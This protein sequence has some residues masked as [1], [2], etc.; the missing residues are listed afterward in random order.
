MLDLT[1][2]LNDFDFCWLSIKP[3]LVF[4]FFVRLCIVLHVHVTFYG[5]FLREE[6]N[7][8][9]MRY[10]H[11]SVRLNLRYTCT[12]DREFFRIQRWYSY[13]FKFM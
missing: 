12:Q 3:D 5:V 4:T 13:S 9:L 11:T 7:K 10:T 1:F 2:I 8:S 6:N